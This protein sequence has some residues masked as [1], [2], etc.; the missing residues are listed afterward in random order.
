MAERIGTLNEVR[1]AGKARHIGVSNFNTA[2][3]DE[4]VGGCW[5]LC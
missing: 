4:A 3:M 1:E 2:Q 5:N